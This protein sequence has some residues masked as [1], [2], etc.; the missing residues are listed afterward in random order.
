MRHILAPSWFAKTS[1]QD[2]SI[3]DILRITSQLATKRRKQNGNQS[4]P[5]FKQ[6]NI[7]A[8]WVGTHKKRKKHHDRWQYYIHCLYAL[9]N[10]IKQ[11]SREADS[12]S[13]VQYTPRISGNM[14]FHYI[15]H[16]RPPLDLIL[17][18]IKPLHTHTITY[19]RQF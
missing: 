10:S 4:L 1:E 3:A 11:S 19:S 17:R 18:Q 6:H 2:P 9:S 14:K 7:A 16:K 8:C 13:T 15:F 5:T 12:H